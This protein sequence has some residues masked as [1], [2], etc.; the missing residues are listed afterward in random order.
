M[1]GTEIL[2]R[3]R[4]YLFLDVDP[5]DA[6]KRISNTEGLDWLNDAISRLYQLNPTVT[7]IN[8]VV[9]DPPTALTDLSSDSGINDQFNTAL[10][11]YLAYRFYSKDTED[12]E[13]ARRAQQFFN[14]FQNSAGIS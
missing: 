2:K 8:T 11:N 12:N 6:Q 14:L 10:I 4:E 9:T 7:Y 1:T 3:A 5:I 13:N